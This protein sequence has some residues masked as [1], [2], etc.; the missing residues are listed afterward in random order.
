MSK[1]RSIIQG[2]KGFFITI[3]LVFILFIIIS[4]YKSWIVDRKGVFTAG[5]VIRFELGANNSKYAVFLFKSNGKKIYGNKI[6]KN[7]FTSDSTE[8]VINKKY[9]VKYNPEDPN[10]NTILFNYKLED[11]INLGT[12]L[13]QY[14]S[15]DIKL[16]VA[17]TTP[18][19]QLQS[20]APQRL[21]YRDKNHGV[22]SVEK[23]VGDVEIVEAIS[24]IQP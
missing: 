20:L 15:L 18:T 4:I 10:I 1:I 8:P 16:K 22:V 23:S 13:H 5:K 24:T 21:G 7:R 12:V 2:N 17:F 3:L 19:L 11:T 14:D 9:L 6:Y